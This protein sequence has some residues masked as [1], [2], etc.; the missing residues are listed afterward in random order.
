MKVKNITESTMYITGSVLKK[1]IY[2]SI[3][4][5]F[6]NRSDFINWLEIID[7]GNIKFDDV[8][9]KTI[10]IKKLDF[11]IF[12]FEIFQNDKNIYKVI[13][14][15]TFNELIEKIN[16][17]VDNEKI[18]YNLWKIENNIFNKKFPSESCLTGNVFHI[19][20]QTKDIV[21]I[22]QLG[23]RKYMDNNY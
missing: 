1:D 7:K 16:L 21:E 6:N 12:I 18:Y 13:D 14:E 2:K 22:K 15:N 20:I 23:I 11:P 17:D 8:N 3:Y 9:I 5:L 10:E 4:S 19:H